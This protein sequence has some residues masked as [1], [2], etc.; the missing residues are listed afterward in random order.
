MKKSPIDIFDVKPEPQ[1][2]PRVL[3]DLDGVIRDFVGSLVKV[4]KN[5]Y[6]KHDIKPITSRRL[7]DF[8]PIGE[9]I[10]HFIENGNIQEIMEDAEAYPGTIEILHKW[11]TKFEIVVATA[12]PEF[13]RNST[14]LW[15]GKNNIPTNEIHISY[16]KSSLNGMALL[17]D[18]S[19]NLADF[20]ATGR[21]AVCLD[22]AWNL[23]WK[24][25]RVKTVN[26]F[27]IYLQSKIDRH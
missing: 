6:P 11:K 4:Y 19:D 26:E 2:L 25:P 12:Q 7:E 15:I 20:A 27:F 17:D 23:D 10:Y 1:D 13:S 24:G 18:F 5:K 21:I 14:I 8:F 22:Q 16:N 3:I 9:G